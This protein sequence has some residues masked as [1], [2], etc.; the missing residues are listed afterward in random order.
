MFMIFFENVSFLQNDLEYV[1]LTLEFFG[2]RTFQPDLDPDAPGGN[3]AD[4]KNPKDIDFAG[5]FFRA[6]FQ[7]SD[8][9]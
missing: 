3:G 1:R 6:I 2:R 8:S 9:A 7:C 5:D 4:L